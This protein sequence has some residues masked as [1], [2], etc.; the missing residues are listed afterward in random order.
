MNVITIAVSASFDAQ[1]GASYFSHRYDKELEKI[2]LMKGR[3]I[4]V[5]SGLRFRP[6]MVEKAWLRR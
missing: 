4:L 1:S 5:Y 3:F 2:N 6:T